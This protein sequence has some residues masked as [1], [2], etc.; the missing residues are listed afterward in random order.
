[1]EENN[2]YICIHGHFY[3]PPRENPW[4]NEIEPEISAE[5]YK[6]WNVRITRECYG[7]NAYARILNQKGQI[8][9]L[10]NNY[11]KISFNFGPTLISWME[12]RYPKLYKKILNADKIS[13]H[14]NNGHG[15]AIA[16][17]Y[18]HII[19]PLATRDDK[20]IEIIWGIE[21]FKRRFNRSP[22]GMWLSETAVDIE[23][24]ELLIEHDI[25]F[26]ILSPTQ[27]KRVK[28]IG[29]ENWEE[30]NEFSINTSQV[31]ELKIP[32]GKKIAL[33]FYEREISSKIAFDSIL[34][35]GNIFIN[36]IFNKFDDKNNEAQL[37]NVASDGETY[38]HHKKFAEMALAYALDQIESKNLAKIINYGYFLELFPPKH[39]V[40]IKENTAWSCSHGVERWRSNCG[41]RFNGEL[42]QKWRTP[43]R[44]AMNWLR[45]KVNGFLENELPKYFKDIKK[46]KEEYIDVIL[47]GYK[48][49][50]IKFIKKFQIRELTE[51]E[52]ITVSRI[53]EMYKNSLLMFTSCGWYFDDISGLE[54]IQIMK[55]AARILQL[56][57][58]FHINFSEDYLKIIERA[59][60]NFKLKGNGRIIFNQV[61]KNI[62]GFRKVVANYAIC[63]LLFSVPDEY[64]FYIYHIE[65]Q[66][67]DVYELGSVKLLVGYTKIFID[68]TGRNQTLMYICLNYRKEFLASA[69]KLEDK[70]DY[71]SFKETIFQKFKKMGLSEII[72]FIDKRF[73]G[74][75]FG[76]E[77]LFSTEQEKILEILIDSQFVPLED[78]FNEFYEDNLK[79]MTYLASI[80]AKIPK[81]FLIVL[82]YILNQKM[83][84]KLSEHYF[85]SHDF[86]P[87]MNVLDEAKF[88][89]LRL[90]TV[91]ISDELSEDI[92]QLIEDIK[93][94]N[95]DNPKCWNYLIRTNNLLQ[96]AIQY[97]LS[98]NSWKFQNNFIEI[99]E[100]NIEL[101][102]KILEI[103][104][105]GLDPQYIQIKNMLYEI[106]IKLNIDIDNIVE[107]FYSKREIKLMHK[108]AS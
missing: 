53:L 76:L 23:T 92:G 30:V 4:L 43:L 75:L 70:K 80:G 68:Y 82:S 66:E 24:I 71:L 18:N 67:M 81:K 36:E 58:R 108:F 35:D 39:E 2:K 85:R 26:I 9:K 11:E 78:A 72:R 98:I 93:K 95:L 21:D 52:Q 13:Q 10:V 90:D 57:E 55:Y 14:D 63:K 59:E 19:M 47:N 7:P 34:N 22:E 28:K 94:C 5:P 103:E 69:K 20:E 1:M 6:N 37:I 31:Y 45:S 107:Y 84:E 102:K 89:R 54:T 88:W 50:R 100:N 106:G 61:L 77:D 60:S 87:I 12:K 62:I 65:N 16:Q 86:R 51:S 44:E 27:A 101:L 91:M 41:C 83:K 104:K 8:I 29:S 79:F 46:A 73:E 56:F 64:D 48:E 32:N 17:I 15:N 38:G 74:E 99:I 105:S 3:Q 97:K 42:N 96:L 40:E 33:F 49:S 25:K